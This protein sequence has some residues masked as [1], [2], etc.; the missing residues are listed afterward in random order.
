MWINA[1]FCFSP[2]TSLEMWASCN[3]VQAPTSQD[4]INLPKLQLVCMWKRQ[5]WEKGGLTVH[6]LMQVYVNVSSFLMN[7]PTSAWW[8]T[9]MDMGSTRRHSC[10][11][12]A[13]T[14]KPWGIITHSCFT[15]PAGGLQITFWTVWR[16]VWAASITVTKTYQRHVSHGVDH[17]SL[18]LHSILSDSAQP[19]LQHVIAI[20][21]RLLCSRLHP[22]LELQTQMLFIFMHSQVG[23]D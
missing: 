2:W 4:I 1:G 13:A 9:T 23:Q 17:N 22:H 10:V 19:R 15:H 20:E 7:S 21:E 11:V 8:N 14:P 18:V 5:Q 6:L 3:T 16:W 12:L